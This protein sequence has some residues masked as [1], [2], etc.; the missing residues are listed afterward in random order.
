MKNRV[1]ILL[2]SLSF[3][4]LVASCSDFLDVN[5]D[6]NNPTSVTVKELLPSA[7]AAI[8]YVMGN[9]LQIIGGIYS[10]YWTQNPG[11]SQYSPLE[12]YEQNSS[13]TN[14][15]W[16]VLYTEALQ[17]LRVI[18]QKA[19]AGGLKQYEAISKILQAYT[20]HVLTDCF[21]DIPYT[22]AF[23]SDKNNLSPKYDDG[24]S[25]YNSILTL[26]ADAEKIIDATDPV[27]P[28]ADDLIY[29]GVM[30]EWVRFSNTLKLR[31]LM[32]LSEVDPTKAQTEIAKL[33]KAEF[34]ST[35]ESGK[36]SYSTTGGNTNPLYAAIVG[37]GN[38]QNL[39]ASRT[40]IDSFAIA[41]DPRISIF[42]V[43]LTNGNYVGNLQGAYNVPI[44]ANSISL[45]SA[46]VGARANENS[47]KAPVIFISSA[48]S[49]FLQAEAISRGW[50][51]STLTAEEAYA[52]AI[53]SNFLDNGLTVKQ[54]D[55]TVLINA[56]FPTTGTLQQKVRAI[57][58]QKWLSMCGT[59]GFEAWT[60]W[61]RTGY[62]TLKT[63]VNSTL[64]A[65]V[66]P[67]RLIYPDRERNRNLNAPK[68]IPDIQVKLWWDKN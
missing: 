68:T 23:Q 56:P 3:S 20:F 29:G 2:A 14:G 32:R 6:P 39:L 13:A 9:D 62:P 19:K 48:E 51:K 34:L 4:M 47:A 45:P 49:Y 11:A 42:Y 25:V 37:L 59:Q 31:V 17:N 30:E 28:G 66:F 61:R 60:E 52:D 44:V 67:S 33:E 54:A 50:L 63:S 8:A 22:E 21:G 58:N 26:I 64:P 41:S 5:T 12:R 55:T 27:H 57:I 53:Y 35:G 46:N 36:V 24:Q 15:I 1:K 65:G 16:Q 18:E 7:Q 43:P 10:Q 40:A 38:T